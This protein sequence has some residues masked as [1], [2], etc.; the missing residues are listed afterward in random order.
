MNMNTNLSLG[1]LKST[2]L[3]LNNIFFWE[4]HFPVWS[5]P[6]KFLDAE[7][8]DVGTQDNSLLLLFI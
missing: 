6:F 4:L 1:Q 7:H 8:N 2:K 3:F 5:L